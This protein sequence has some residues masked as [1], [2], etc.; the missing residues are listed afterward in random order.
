M[1]VAAWK[2]VSA[3][4]PSLTDAIAAGALVSMVMLSEHTSPPRVLQPASLART[5]T[6]YLVA[7]TPVAT[8]LR[9]AV[10]LP[11]LVTPC[12]SALMPPPVRQVVFAGPAPVSTQ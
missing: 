3:P 6:Q 4:A 9:L 7:L 2:S 1:P 10:V 5:H 8:L 12:R 11:V